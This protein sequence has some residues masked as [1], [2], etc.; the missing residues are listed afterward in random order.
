[1]ALTDRITQLKKEGKTDSDVIT[2]LIQEGNTPTDINEALSQISIKPADAGDD[3]QPSIMASEAPA[4]EIPAAAPAEQYASPPPQYAQQ[5]QYAEY[6][7]ASYE[8]PAQQ[9]YSQYADAGYYQQQPMDIETIKDLSRQVLEESIGRLKEQMTAVVQMKSEVSAQIIDMENRLSKVESIIEQIQSSII[10]KMGDY[11][12]SITNIS[13]EIRSTQEAF[14]KMVNPLIDKQRGMAEEKKE[15]VQEQ[16]REEPVKKKTVK[17]A[18][19][20][21]R[22]SEGFESYLR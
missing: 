15:I 1:M 22:S 8:Q 13:H 5:E 16:T 17:S 6:P 18:D 20:E 14:A 21:K 3:M 9:D 19:R 12:E 4:T 10:R 11:G 2:A 7:Q